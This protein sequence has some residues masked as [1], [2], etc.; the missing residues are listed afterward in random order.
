MGKRGVVLLILIV[1]VIFSGAA[2][3]QST[4]SPGFDVYTPD[5]VVEPGEET[6]VSVILENEGQ[7]TED[8]SETEEAAVTEARG[9]TAELDSGDA[10]VSV[11]SGEAQLG[12]VQQ[13]QTATESFDITVDGDA[14][15]G[16]YELP[17][18]LTYTYT[19]EVDG[20]EQAD[21]VTETTTET[22]EIEIDESSQFEIEGATS[23]VSAGESGES[24]IDITNTGPNDASEAVVT[25]DAP[26]SNLDITSQSTDI[27]IGEWGAG[28]T[29]AIDFVTELDED[30]LAQDY[31]IYATVEYLDENENE[32]TSRQLRTGIPTTEGQGFSV[33]SV[34]S[35]LWVG[36]DG[37]VSGE[38][39]NEGPNQ[40]DNVVLQ[41]GDGGGEE[42]DILGDVG[43]SSSVD[44]GENVEPRETQY[45]VGTLSS[46]E[47]AQFSFP[48]AVS[49]EAEPG[50]R[51]AEVTTRY[52]TLGGDVQTSDPL[53]L[54][55]EI[56]DER[57]IFTVESQDPEASEESDET[58][59]ETEETDSTDDATFDPGETSTLEIAVTN[60]HDETLSNVRA[61]TFTNDPLE[62]ADSEV[63]IPEIEPGETELLQFD[64]EVSEGADPQSYPVEIDFQYD[65]E[66][67]TDQLSDT[68]QVP[69]T[70]TEP[71]DDGLSWALVVFVGV[72]LVLAAL[73]WWFR[74]DIREWYDSLDRP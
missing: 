46:G 69:V 57:D 63:F 24:T 40:V 26:D 55:V 37:E 9:V 29:E 71:A 34:E 32:Q 67:N 25:L 72:I 50:P 51:E 65:D 6:A 36:E 44:L 60:D 3:A 58:G 31:T 38:I 41:L 28:E 17:L 64:L 12:S 52:R 20:D 59:A 11:N 21:E 70:V 48:L 35:D 13:E 68:Y 14:Q 56:G 7:I 19:P 62:I 43:E 23:G 39:T 27:Y 66:E 47:S 5:N 2:Y 42:L 45:S 53:D 16:T 18:E 8:G 33:D 10:P 30:A 49:S 1:T 73:A 54:S 22:V 74:D 61:Q 4:G 15:P